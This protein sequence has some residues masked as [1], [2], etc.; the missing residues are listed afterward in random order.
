M[1]FSL[2]NPVVIVFSLG[3]NINLD[4]WALLLPKQS[5]MDYICT[6]LR[7]YEFQ[8]FIYTSVL[9]GSTF[10]FYWIGQKIHLGFFHNILQKSMSRL[11]NQIYI[12][13][14]HHH[15]FHFLSA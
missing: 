11:A 4:S 2:V 14:I 1:Q 15:V 6:V 9:P 10:K 13:K 8:I 5:I 12:F 7:L 3:H